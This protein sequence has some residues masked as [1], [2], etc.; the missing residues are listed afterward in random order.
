[1]PKV[2]GTRKQKAAELLERIERGPS[3]SDTGRTFTL[4]EAAEQ[5]QRW[6]Q[7]WIIQPLHELVPELKV[8]GK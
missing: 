7:S 3:F 4:A 8:R 6:A 1:M 2:R 5:Y